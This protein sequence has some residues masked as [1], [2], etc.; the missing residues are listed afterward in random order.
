MAS[1]SGLSGSTAWNASVRSRLYLERLVD[2]G[3]EPNPNR[4]RLTLK[5]ANHAAL[6]AEIT[7]TW[8]APGIFVP[9]PPEGGLDRMAASTKAK[10]V[11]LILLDL[12]TAQGRY[13]SPT[14]CVTFAPAVFAKQPEAEGCTPRALSA[15]MESLLRSGQV[16]IAEHGRGASKRKHLESRTT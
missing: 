1:G 4:R 13:V 8:R 2:D 3:F 10:R 15:A 7:M 6:G 11:F 12:F 16:V 9:D 14:P 5:K